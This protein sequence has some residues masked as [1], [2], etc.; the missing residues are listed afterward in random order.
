MRSWFVFPVLIVA[1]GFSGCTREDT[2]KA[3]RKAGKT[4]HEIAN[5]TEKAAKK[6]GNEIKDAAREA[7]EGWKEGSP[8]KDAKH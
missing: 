8:A 3:A 7:R 1:L 2:D 4:A 5:K 6:V